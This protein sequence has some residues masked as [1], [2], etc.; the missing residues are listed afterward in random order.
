MCN[1]GALALVVICGCTCVS[2]VIFIVFD[3]NIHWIDEW[4]DLYV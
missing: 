4:V 2:N 1:M 3:Y